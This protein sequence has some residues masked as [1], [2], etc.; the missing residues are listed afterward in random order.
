MECYGENIHKV[1]EYSGQCENITLK[2][3]LYL[4][5]A[6]GAQGGNF[7][8]DGSKGGY[9]R[10]VYRCVSPTTITVCVGGKGTEATKT[11]NKGGFNGGGISSFSVYFQPEFYQCGTGGGMTS[12]QDSSDKSYLLIAGGGG[13]STHFKKQ[14]TGDVINYKGGFGGGSSGGNGKGDGEGDGAG[15]GGSSVEGG[16]GGNY[17]SPDGSYKDCAGLS[18]SQGKGGDGVTT[19]QACPGGG[20][21][22]YYGG[23]GGA[24]SGSGGGGSG[25]F[26]PSLLRAELFSGGES[27]NNPYCTIENGHDGDGYAKITFVYKST[28]P[29]PRILHSISCVFYIFLIKKR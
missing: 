5:E 20:G 12:F 29:S 19:A 10:G 8:T 27:F 22:G 4:L 24:D 28:F 18:G 2:K 23:G 17:H 13:G 1:F 15:T 14:N 26:S 3:G 9:S 11:N 6:W 25:Y 21:G 7:T 16:N